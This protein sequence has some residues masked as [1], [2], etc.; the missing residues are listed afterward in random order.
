[1]FKG[2]KWSLELFSSGASLMGRSW[3]LVIPVIQEEVNTVVGDN[4]DEVIK[5][6]YP[7]FTEKLRT[8]SGYKTKIH[9]DPK[10]APRFGKARSVSYSIK[11]KVE[12]ELTRLVAENILEPVTFS[13]W[14]ASI[15][16]I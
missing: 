14:A 10:A 13:D 3:L 11:V 8:L 1:M 7:L 4:L 12:E 16:T 2:R 6:A 9:V 5:K 15:V